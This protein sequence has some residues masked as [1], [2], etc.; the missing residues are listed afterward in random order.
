MRRAV[1]NVGLSGKQRRTCGV[2][3]LAPPRAYFVPRLTAMPL[4]AVQSRATILICAKT[5]CVLTTTIY[6]ELP[7][8]LRRHQHYATIPT[9][10]VHSLPLQESLSHF[11]HSALCHFQ[12]AF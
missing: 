1:H 9:P 3:D 11:L 7:C 2:Q 5:T 6:C 4:L 10:N 8:N 12:C